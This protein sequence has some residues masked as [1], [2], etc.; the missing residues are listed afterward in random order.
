MRVAFDI[1]DTIY[2]VRV[3]YRDQAPDYDLIPVLIWFAKNG[4]EVYV[5]SAGGLDYAKTIVRKLGL[6]EYVTAVIPKPKLHGQDKNID[7]CF[8]DCEVDLATVTVRVNRPHHKEKNE[9]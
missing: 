1:D 6:D 8:D 4:D 3:K 2:K 7:L 5:W 9:K